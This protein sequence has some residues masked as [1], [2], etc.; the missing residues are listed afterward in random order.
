[1]LVTSYRDEYLKDKVKLLLG[2]SLYSSLKEE[3][4][5]LAG[6]AITSLFCNREIKDYDIYFRSKYSLGRVM[7]D[8]CKYHYNLSMQDIRFIA[9][10]QKSIMAEANNNT[11]NVQFITCAYFGDVIDIFKSFDF[12]VCMG[13]FDFG[14]ECFFLEENFL[15]HNSQRY[16]KF[17]PGTL[18]PII[19]ALR[20][21]K[22][23]DKGYSISKLEMMRILAKI[24]EMKITSWEEAEDHFGGMYGETLQGIVDQNV[25]FSLEVLIEALGKETAHPDYTKTFEYKDFSVE[26]IFEMLDIPEENKESKFY[27]KT[28]GADGYSC[29]VPSHTKG[30]KIKYEAG[31][32]VNG[33]SLGVFCVPDVT[34]VYKAPKLVKL[35]PVVEEKYVNGALLG[36]VYVVDVMD[37]DSAE[38]KKLLERDLIDY[39]NELE[40]KE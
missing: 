10:T 20:V 4:A 11:A 14:K 7:L 26:E 3:K 27:Y 16:L 29:H 36:H 13:A 1:M 9:S 21:S 39:L 5:F 34:K 8:A 2:D 33:G 32:M 15:K 28:V 37:Y 30:E 35:F 23:K 40:G 22:Y 25:D 19:S 12:T 6:G 31:T 24:C 18:Y 38:A 17:N